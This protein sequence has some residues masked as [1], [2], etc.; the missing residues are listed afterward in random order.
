MHHNLINNYAFIR[1]MLVTMWMITKLLKLLNNK[2]LMTMT[3]TVLI[4]LTRIIMI[5]VILMIK[6]TIKI[7]IRR[8]SI[9]IKYTSINIFKMFNISLNS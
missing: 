5:K 6:I 7:K 1:L 4:I 3:T 2:I 9:V 8:I